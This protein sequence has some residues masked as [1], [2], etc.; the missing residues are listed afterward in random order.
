MRNALAWAFSLLFGVMG[1]KG[2]EP[3]TGRIT[4]YGQSVAMCD[5]KILYSVERKNKENTTICA[6]VAPES[7]SSE[8]L[9]VSVAT[10]PDW[11]PLEGTHT[12]DV[13]ARRQTPTGSIFDATIRVQGTYPATLDDTIQEGH[14]FYSG[15]YFGF[16]RPCGSRSESRGLH[17]V[18]TQGGLTALVCAPPTPHAESG[19]PH[20]RAR[21]MNIIDPIDRPYYVGTLEYIDAV[22]PSGKSAP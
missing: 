19:V 15:M 16:A 7:L 12:F 21:R 6:A 1:C 4:N 20:V 14:T 17:V 5:G 9:P 8:C 22:E 10:V 11:N 2:Y 3:F 18:H 13:T